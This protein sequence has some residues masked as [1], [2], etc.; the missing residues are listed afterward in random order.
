VLAARGWLRAET[1]PAQTATKVAVVCAALA[2]A[3]GGGVAAATLFRIDLGL[4]SRADVLPVALAL[5]GVVLLLQMVRRRFLVVP[6]ITAPVATLLTVYLAV[7]FLGIP[8]LERSR[9]TAPLGRWISRHTKTTDAI[10]AYGLEDW[11]ASIRYYSDRRVVPLRQ[12]EDVRAF[13][14]QSRSSYVMMLRLDYDD[15]RA[16]GLGLIE[17]SRRRAIVGRTGKYVRRQVWG[18]LLIVTDRDNPA[19]FALDTTGEDPP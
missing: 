1:D 13:F 4:D 18:D 19:V 10:G 17:V 16:A 2:L 6:S 14:N 12:P 3:V 8:I 15:L 7:I 5:G 11:R 9:P